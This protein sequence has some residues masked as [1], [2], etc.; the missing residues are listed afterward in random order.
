MTE[1][2]N[3]KS[4]L[5]PGTILKRGMYKVNRYL[6]S[7]NFGNTYVVFSPNY[8]RPLAMKEFFLSGFCLRARDGRTITLSPSANPQTF[9]TQ[10]EKFKKEGLRLRGLQSP[11]VVHVHD[12]FEENG[13]VYYIMDY[14]NGES[15]ADLLERHKMPFSEERTMKIML[16]IL[17]A[18]DE[19][20]RKQIWHLDLKPDNVM[21]DMNTGNVVVIDFGASK[22]LG[23]QGRYTGTT[24]ILCYTP[25]F[26]P[27][28]QVSQDL[29]SVGPWT[30]IYALGAT[31]YN[32][33]TN[34]TPPTFTQLQEKKTVRFPENVSKPMRAM[35]LWM[36]SPNRMERPQ[37]VAAV[38]GYIKMN[39]K[40]NA[41]QQQVNMNGQQQQW[42]QKDGGHP[43]AS[44]SEI[45]KPLSNKTA[46]IVLGVVLAIMFLI[47]LITSLSSGGGRYAW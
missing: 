9:I 4:M 23:L 29:S 38:Y 11:H 31:I 45:N 47:V 15:L 25:G 16:Q 44:L 14:V 18:L 34:D 17:E 19:I 27:M 5:P 24:G 37:S 3:Y 26:A 42:Q 28:E 12:M 2:V 36:M 41:F 43:D 10:R 8:N 35:I 21:L 40:G 39:M 1:N 20:H 46:L 32:L 13:T 30:D 6:A 22:Q 7:G 33:L